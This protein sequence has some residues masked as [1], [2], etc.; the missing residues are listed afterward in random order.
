[1]SERPLK[2]ILRAIAN[3]GVPPGE[4][5]LWP[6]LRDGLTEDGISPRHRFLSPARM[7]AALPALIVMA[8]LIAVLAVVGPD[9]ALAALRGLLGYIPGIGLVDETAGLRVLAAP[10]ALEQDGITVTIGQAVLDSEQAVIVYQADGIPAGAYPRQEG[11]PFC[12]LNPELRL[13]DGAVLQI[14]GGQGGGWASGY[15]WRLVYPAIPPEVNEATLFIPCLFDTPP[16]AAPENWK[17]TLYFIPA[18]PDMTVV[19]VLELT[20]PPEAA[21]AEEGGAA[22]LYLERVIELE[23]SY[24]LAGTFRQGEGLPGAVVLGMSS[25]PEITVADGQPWPFDVPSDL[26]LPAHEMGVIPWAYQV[27]KGFTTPL[28]LTF[29]AVDV[30]FPAEATFQLDAGG[31]PQAGQEWALDQEL[32]VAGHTT[33]LVSAVRLENGYEFRFTSDPSVSGLSVVDEGNAPL[34]GFGGGSEG[35][36]TVGF[37]YAPPVPAGVLKFRIT[38]LLA[39]QAGPWTLTWEPPGG[40]EPVAATLIPQACLTLDRWL[41]AA[42][43]PT[44][45]P[46][47]L[48]GRLIAYGRIRDDGQPLSPEN[49]GVYVVDLEGG[50]RQVLGPGTWPSL[51]PDGARAAYSWT[52]GLHVADL[53]SGEDNF[54][55]GTTGGDYNPRWSPD[56]SQIA[57]VRTDDLNLYVV[58]AD[59][60]PGPQRVT[61]G[62]EYELLVGWLPDGQTLSYAFPGPE[63]MHLRFLD[64]STG[65]VRDGFVFDSKGASAAISPDGGTIAFVGRVPGRMG[66]GL[67]LARLDGSDRRLIAQLDDWGISDPVWSPDGAWLIASIAN[68]D[69]LKPE[70]V[71][72]LINLETCQAI[73][74]PGIEGYV[75]GWGP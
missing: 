49:A 7:R 8:L 35:E 38:G 72:A 62:P 52:D 61:E 11:A 73:P 20:P 64:R 5:D 26:E 53:A 75:Q 41:Q 4:V 2:A 27:P 30:E 39:R 34:G 48:A 69:V 13:P 43:N 66:Y 28:T 59:N 23:E 44:P 70:V 14:V 19:P 33:R 68:A 47:A 46:E 32:Q 18:P 55:P 24:I 65:A 31:D 22:G 37:E 40:V 15:E 29:E 56:G 57:F 6:R 67:Y 50:E 16:G 54:L 25:W 17:L 36:F 74:L 45:P 12:N 3:E 63:G 58:D 51:S 1:M 60:G 9:K 21:T 10:V 42:E 71:P